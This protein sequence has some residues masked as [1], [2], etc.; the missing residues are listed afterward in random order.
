MYT[1]RAALF[2]LISL[3]SAIKFYGG[4]LGGAEQNQNPGGNQSDS[5]DSRNHDRN[6]AGGEADRIP[7]WH[8][9]FGQLNHGGVR[10]ENSRGGSYGG[11]VDMP[12]KN[13]GDYGVHPQNVDGSCYSNAGSYQRGLV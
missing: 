2:T 4:S 6:I 7:S 3:R 13:G 9:F 11:R 12:V 1:R 5:F 10:L 8:N